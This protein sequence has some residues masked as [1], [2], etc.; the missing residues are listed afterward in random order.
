MVA[1]ISQCFLGDTCQSKDKAIFSPNFRRSMRETGFTCL[2]SSPSCKATVWQ[3]H[4]AAAQPTLSYPEC[5]YIYIYLS[6]LIFP[7]S[8]ILGCGQCRA[9]GPG[10]VIWIFPARF[11]KTSWDAFE[12]VFARIYSIFSGICNPQK[13]KRSGRLFPTKRRLFAT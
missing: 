13:K 8:L 4:R 1:E 7:I 6:P 5:V 11:G 12:L 2:K 10:L 9:L 3:Q